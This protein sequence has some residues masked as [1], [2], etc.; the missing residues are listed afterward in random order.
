MTWLALFLSTTAVLWIYRERRHAFGSALAV[1]CAALA[2]GV[3]TFA[4][5]QIIPTR[6]EALAQDWQQLSEYG[7]Y[8][9][10]LGRRAELWQIGV[11]AVRE[12]PMI[13]HGPQSTKPIIHDGFA[14]IGMEVNYSHLH[15]GFLNAWV[16]A[17]IVGALSL[18]AIFVV[19]AWLAVRTL[20]TTAAP[21]ARL[22][23]VMLVALVTTYV[24]NGQVGIL[25]GH[26]I[27]DAMLMAFLAVGVY[28]AAGKS[29]LRDDVTYIWRFPWRVAFR[30]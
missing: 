23:A 9:S 26:D 12:S 10:S 15:N 6:V 8:D 24:V 3:V 13:G 22:G 2:I 1:T 25:V 14:K 7:D 20:A 30:R 11:A 17:G 27:L 28:L 18:A 5:A 16:E 21:D 4:G 19:A 29:M